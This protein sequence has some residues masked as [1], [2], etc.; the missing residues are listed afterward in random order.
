MVVKFCISSIKLIIKRNFFYKV[1]QYHSLKNLY[2]YFLD[3]FCYYLQK[4]MVSK[5]KYILEI[6]KHFSNLDE[7]NY[8]TLISPQ[9]IQFNNIEREYLNE[10]VSCSKII[11]KNKDSG[12]TQREV[13]LCKLKNVKFFGH[14]GVLAIKDKPLLETASTLARLSTFVNS[15]DNIFLKHRKMKGVYTSIMHIFPQVFYHFLIES[16]P[17]FYGISK[18]KE[19]EIN[20]IVPWPTR[21]WQFKI[22]KIFLD[23]RF[24]LISIKKNEVW[25]LETFYFSSFFDIDCSA[26]FPKKISDFM[27]NK[28]FTYYGIDTKNVE[29][30]RRIYL[31]RAKIGHR[32]IRNREG[33]LNLIKRYGFEE[34]HPQDLSFKEQVEII[35][36]ADIIIGMTGSAMSNLIF[37]TN[38]KVIILFSDEIITHYL[39]MC[40]SLNFTYRQI[41]GYDFNKKHDCQVDLN[42]FEEILKELITK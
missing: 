20:L 14:T 7:I 32:I 28:V 30:K 21:Q 10:N 39:L 4:R 31:S 35:N 34:I 27:R 12:Y 18:I 16:I 33:F 19:E 1:P 42:N 3:I 29:R 41:I 13:F 40:K 17:R 2:F 25:E 38:L 8:E 24:K 37:G 36:S 26:Y 22:L 11:K 23:K 5:K 6:K 15:V 9:K